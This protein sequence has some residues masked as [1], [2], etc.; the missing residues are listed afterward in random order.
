MHLTRL[1]SEKS[2]AKGTAASNDGDEV[3]E[4]CYGGDPS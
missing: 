4:T 1:D 3:V 2:P